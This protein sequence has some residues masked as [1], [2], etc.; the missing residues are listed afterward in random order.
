MATTK[1]CGPTK[2]RKP[3]KTKCGGCNEGLFDNMLTEFT[4][5]KLHVFIIM[6]SV[7]GLGAL[8]AMMMGVSAAQL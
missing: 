4:S 5:H 2:G 8:F 6:G 1:K 7:L 3:A